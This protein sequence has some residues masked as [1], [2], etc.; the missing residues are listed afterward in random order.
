M[1]FLKKTQTIQW[2]Y[3]VDWVC[4]DHMI[5][6]N[7]NKNNCTKIRYIIFVVISLSLSLS[8]SIFQ[9]ILFINILQRRP[10]LAF[11]LPGF[12]G[13]LG[14]WAGWFNSRY[15]PAHSTEESPKVKH[16]QIF[17]HSNFFGLVWKLSKCFRS[18]SLC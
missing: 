18:S 10:S 2:P 9:N 17:T 15:T 6:L 16:I 3:F 12:G 7:R 11:P 1:K 8:R 14:F 5:L 4:F 13:S